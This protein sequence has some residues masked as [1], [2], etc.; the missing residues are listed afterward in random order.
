VHY[1]F[2]KKKTWFHIILFIIRY[3]FL[4]EFSVHVTDKLNFYVQYMQLYLEYNYHCLEMVE[5]TLCTT[6]Y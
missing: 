2:E 6:Y 3:P 5:I 1:S 4:P